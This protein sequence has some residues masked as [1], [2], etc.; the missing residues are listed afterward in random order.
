MDLLEQ[1]DIKVIRGLEHL[2]S[3]D[4]LG[5]LELYSLEKRR[6][7]GDPITD[8]QYLKGPYK[9]N[10]TKFLAGPVASE[11]FKLKDENIMYYEGSNAL[12]RLAQR[13]GRCPSSEI[14]RGQAEWRFEQPDQAERVPA[15]GRNVG[16]DEL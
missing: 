3:K 12:A 14:V 11:V 6:V 15:H 13:G 4:V 8:F 10:E 5:K 1:R 2:S 7:W 9:N 16:L